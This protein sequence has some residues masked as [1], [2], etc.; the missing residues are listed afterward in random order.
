MNVFNEVE[1][2]AVN[3][4]RP[5]QNGRHFPD[6]IFRRI[7]LNENGRIAINISLNFVP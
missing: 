2:F 4:L 7:I 3:M 5:R 1:R 6:D